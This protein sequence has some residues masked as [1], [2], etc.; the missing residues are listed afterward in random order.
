LEEEEEEKYMPLFSQTSAGLINWDQVEMV[1]EK[2]DHFYICFSRR[3][4]KLTRAQ[5]K[6]EVEIELGDAF[7]EHLMHFQMGIK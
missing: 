3:E 5:W 4:I 6:K 1:F 7:R 2:D